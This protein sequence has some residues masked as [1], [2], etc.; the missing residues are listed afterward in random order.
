MDK[1]VDGCK[2]V[3]DTRTMIQS[4]RHV[5]LHDKI[6]DGDKSNGKKIRKHN[7]AWNRKE[8]RKVKEIDEI[9]TNTRTHTLKLRT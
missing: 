6:V 2:D 7:A 5:G 9:P 1:N 4:I 8:N 3:M